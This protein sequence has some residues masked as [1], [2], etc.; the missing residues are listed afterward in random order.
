MKATAHCFLVMMFMMLYKVVPTFESVD[1]ILGGV[2]IQ[3]KA[4]G[5]NLPVALFLAVSL[6]GELPSN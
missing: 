6:E 5:Q 2:T 4:T 3:I 1:G